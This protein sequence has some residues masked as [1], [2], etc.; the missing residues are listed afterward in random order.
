MV[1]RASTLLVAALVGATPAAASA[2]DTFSGRCSGLEG[3]ATFPEEPMRL[4]PVD[5]LLRARLTGGECSGTLNGRAVD[6]M[7][8]TARADLRGPQSCAFGIT[9]GRFA[10]RLGGRTITGDM[11]YRRFGS[12][13][14]AL[15]QGDGGGAALVLVHAQVGVVSQDDPLA[16]TPIIGPLI[17]APVT[18]A[19]VL[20]RC[21]ADGVSRMPIALDRIA[22]VTALSG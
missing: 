15:W 13:I 18:T 16:A 17:S 19:D 10:F 7:P 1:K 21:A 9:S 12:R 6:G 8:A 14:T 4:A 11:T 20:S 2:A 22:T 3:W 5:M